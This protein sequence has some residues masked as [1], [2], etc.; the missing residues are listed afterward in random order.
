[1]NRPGRHLDLST[2]LKGALEFSRT[3]EGELVTETMLVDGLNDDVGNLTDIA[4]Y[5]AE[6]SPAKAYLSIPTRPP[7]E[8]W[9]RAPAEEILN[10][11]FQIF[12]E[13]IEHVE[14]LIG[15]EGDA[16]ASTGDAVQDVLG[17]T[18]V[19]PM[20]QEAVETLFSTAGVDISL[21]DRLV[22]QRK[23]VRLNYEGK[24]FL[25]RRLKNVDRSQ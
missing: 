14:Y 8:S 16:F 1:V 22:E 4:N 20:R 2:I 7:S 24:D 3:F 17:I 12:A 6:L 15:Y 19:H 13:H 23:L 18:A 10:M 9:V 11:A 5:L 25:V 21:I